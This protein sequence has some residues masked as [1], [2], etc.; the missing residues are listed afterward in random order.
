MR[1]ERPI[2]FALVMSAMLLM[3]AQSYAQ[4]NTGAIKGTVKDETGEPLPGVAVEAKGD[5]LMGKERRS[6]IPPVRS[7]YPLF[8]LGRTMRFL[9]L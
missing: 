8:P 6:P 7:D 4:I 2:V 1:K 5:A 3:V 9:F